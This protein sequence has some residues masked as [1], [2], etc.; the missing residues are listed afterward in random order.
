VAERFKAAVLKTARGFTLPRG[1]ESHPFRQARPRR[2]S[3]LIRTST[4]LSILRRLSAVHVR[5]CTPYSALPLWVIL[6]VRMARTV[7]K[8]KALQVGRTCKPGMY[9]DGAGLYLQVSRSG[10]KSWIYRFTLRGHAR[11]MG[12]GSCATISLSEAR[13]KAAECRRLCHDGID[14]IEH[15][16]ATQEQ[17][18]RN[19]ASAVTFKTAAAAY[20]EAHRPSWH[21]AKHA[22]QWEST[23]ATYVYP[24]MGSVPVQAIDTPLVLKVLQPIWSKKPETAGRIRGRIEA[25][26]D[27]ARASGLRQGDNPALW[28]GHLDQVLPKRS[29]IRAVKHHAALPYGDLP[30]FMIALRQQAGIAA[31]AL[32]FTILTAARTGETIG[33]TRDEIDGVTHVWTVP[34]KRMKAGKDHAVPLTAR[35]SEII[36]EMRRGPGANGEFMFP[37]VKQG[38]PLSNMAMTTVLRRMGRADLTVHGFRSTFRDWAAERTSFPHEVVEMALAHSIGNKVEAAYLRSTLF[39]KRRL[40]MAEWEQ[41]C[42]GTQ[43]AVEM[44]MAMAVRKLQPV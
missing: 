38:H 43:H 14:P 28:R 16:K 12:L 3:R 30:D 25:I 44:P 34:A 19:A 39:D 29:K 18:V 31:R 42:C 37:G 17:N 9:S 23:L 27:W 32:E 24:V 26:L 6:G 5:S 10:A 35:P 1:F 40:L 13:I 41:Y 4:I 2:C 20:I 15:R 11:E 7:G 22:A 33:G 8:L 21:N 36:D